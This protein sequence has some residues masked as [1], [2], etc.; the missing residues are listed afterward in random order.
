MLQILLKISHKGN[1]LL[2]F[3]FKENFQA[4]TNLAIGGVAPPVELGWPV[5]APLQMR[6]PHPLGGN[7]AKTVDRRLSSSACRPRFQMEH[8]PDEPPL[9]DGASSPR[10][11]LQT[12]KRKDN[13]L[14]RDEQR[15]RMIF[16]RKV[17]INPLYKILLVISL[18]HV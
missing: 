17:L 6:Y 7:E 14:R 5:L 10:L 11:Q 16:I 13:M 4:E 18:L 3:F 2:Q 12:S 1:S 9:C 8:V 15:N